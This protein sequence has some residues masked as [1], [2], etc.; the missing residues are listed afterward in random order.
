ML[1]ALTDYNSFSVRKNGKR[2]NYESLVII[3]EYHATLQFNE[4]GYKDPSVGE[5]M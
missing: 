1:E 3:K 4:D 2:L 5:Y